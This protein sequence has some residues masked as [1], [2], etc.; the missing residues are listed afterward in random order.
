ML[1]T[2]RTTVDLD[3]DVLQASKELAAARGTTMGRVLSDLARRGLDASPRA[4]G[5]RNG[6]PLL[7]RRPP[8]SVRPTMKLVRELLDDD[9]GGTAIT[10]LMARVALLDVNV[11]VALFDPD[12]IHHELAHDWFAEQRPAGWATCPLT[13]NGFV[14][15]LSH[16][17]YGPTPARASWLIERLQQFCASG[18]HA[19]WPDAVSL[20]DAS[21]FPSP[22]TVGHRQVT[23][24]YLLG[25]A[26][27]M[28]GALATFDRSITPATVRGAG[29]D[30][31]LTIEPV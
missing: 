19:F 24:V 13:E 16:P 11:L 22:A 21:L 29:I 6:V 27:K 14:R 18:H 15:V 8:G 12:H 31:L 9:L 2:V 3:A 4:K 28:G 10:S 1:I 30:Q 25:L 17:N 26:T 23:D 7:P 5:V 20:R